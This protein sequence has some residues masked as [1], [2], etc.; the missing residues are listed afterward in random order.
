M[1]GYDLHRNF[2]PSYKEIGKYATDLFTEESIKIIQKHDKANPLLLY[3]SHLAA[4]TGS[5]EKGLELGVPNVEEAHRKFS[6]I[7]DPRRRLYAEIV[8]Q[9]DK[10]VGQVVEALS[11]R[12][13]LSNTIILFMSDNG[14][15]TTGVFENSGSNWPFRG[16]K[17]TVFEGA[18]R[19]LAV[20]WS[21]DIR[22]TDSVVRTP[23]HIADWLPTLYAAAG[24]NSYLFFKFNFSGEKIV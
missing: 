20:L 9:L 17:Q 23:V 6:Y 18:V 22:N 15:P 21:K 4:H 14:A 13:M 2:A 11:R 19:N 10:S 1:N 5:K 24:K 12:H 8:S 3:L 16:I 7:E